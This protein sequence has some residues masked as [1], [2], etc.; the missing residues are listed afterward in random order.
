MSKIISET[1]VYEENLVRP[2]TERTV[3]KR[4]T[5]DGFLDILGSSEIIGEDI[6]IKDSDGNVVRRDSWRKDD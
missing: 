3:H 4:H 5:R 6:V 2:H 1:R